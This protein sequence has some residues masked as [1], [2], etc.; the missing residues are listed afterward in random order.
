MQLCFQVNL[1]MLK[2]MAENFRL[3]KRKKPSQREGEQSWQYD[4][5]DH[6]DWSWFAFCC[7]TGQQ[8]LSGELQVKKTPKQICIIPSKQTRFSNWTSSL[9]QLLFFFLFC[10]NRNKFVVEQIM[11]IYSLLVCMFIHN[12]VNFTKLKPCQWVFIFVAAVAIVTVK[13]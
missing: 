10:I 1:L 12:F 2:E 13:L 5:P 8:I 11:A 7:W 9:G 6:S 4:V 3:K